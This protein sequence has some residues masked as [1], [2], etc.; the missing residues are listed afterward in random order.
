MKRALLIITFAFAVGAQTGQTLAAVK[1]AV[2][3]A[4][5]SLDPRASAASWSEATKLTLPWD[6]VHNRT[7]SE[8]TTLRIASDGRALY[9]RFDA[10]Q[11]E[12]IAASQH[13]NNVGQG[14]DDE[15][16]IDVW[17]NG[18]DGYFYQFL[19][20]PNGTHYAYS[21]ENSDFS[22]TWKS[23]GVE[24]NGGYTVTMSIPFDI[25]RNA[26]SGTWKVQF[27]RFIHATG[28]EQ[29]WSYSRTQPQQDAYGN[30]DYALAGEMLVPA[31]K[32]VALAAPKAR[33]ALYALGESAAQSLG[34][35]TSRVGADLSIPIAPTASLFATFHPDDSN[36]ELDQQSISP[37]VFQRY[38][39]EVRPFF[40]Q[41]ASFYN[42]FNC[43]ACPMNALLYTPAI[44]TPREGYAIEGKHGPFG[45]ASFDA[46]GDGR[47]DLASEFGYSSPDSRWQSSIE[48][49]SVNMPGFVDNATE[50]GTSYS[51]LKHMS[52]YFNYGND[53]GTN[54]LQ[55][56]QSQYYDLGGGW[57]SQ[58]F[59]FGGAL[60]KIG[61]YYDPAD[62][63]VS[64]PGIA[65]YALFNAKIWDFD[66]NSKLASIGLS[67]FLD[68]Y[69]GPTD[70]IAQSDNQ[71]LLDVLT[72]SALDLQVYTGSDY[73][74]FG[75]T[76]T[77]ISQNGG[78]SL[79]YHSGLQTNNPGQFP[80]H[81]SS[82]TPTSINYSTGR[83]GSGRL[84]T[85]FRN[86][87][88]RLGN[89]G[90]LIVALDDT[91]QFEP[92]T[93][94]NIQWFDSV[95]Y[96]YQIARNSSFAIGIRRVLGDPPLPNGGGNCVGRCTN[97]SL[98]YHLRLRHAEFYLAY[99]N[100]NTLSTAPQ[101]IFKVIFYAG[102]EKGT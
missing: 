12:P 78:F 100:P 97:L 59:G 55:G 83:Y 71:L 26:R 88:M 17:P 27:V 73:W 23:E 81:G 44:P 41:A 16:W 67:G 89:R 56:N 36:V 30:A 42:N 6:I 31:P 87:T 84:D 13:T 90:S 63:F 70:G 28:E 25:M 15:V 33:L 72:K 82:A 53:S 29:V 32:G 11:R 96:A 19:A 47:N 94:S 54:V 66:K 85:W 64:H 86:T 95:S 38:Y 35:S 74:R 57:F 45:F 49:T 80:Y 7:S 18:N 50:A 10:S 79:T 37:S 46:L 76:L 1:I 40:T 22:P 98:A 93:A 60:R 99:G 91:A 69:Q 43:V 21:S 65:G 8:R 5:P 68:R 101:A 3:L 24:R 4:S 102:A 51:D 39:S 48:R 34:G 9:L 75:S 58:T 77:P 61:S 20:T 62:G 92:S 2:P 52:A 14:S